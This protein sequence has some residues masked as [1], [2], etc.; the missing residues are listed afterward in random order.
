LFLLIIAQAVIFYRT[1]SSSF[2]V[3]YWW[4]G[5]AASILALAGVV[6]WN[7]LKQQ[8]TLSAR[9]NLFSL[10][11]SRISNWL[12]NVLSFN[13]LYH[14]LEVVYGGLFSVV[15]V[16]SETLE[17]EGGVLWALVLLAL[18]VSIIKTG[19]VAK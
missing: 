12:N 4:A 7:R 18:L 5:A 3:Q 8:T 9:Q 1:F 15:Q 2:R 16:L 6:A 10:I 17:G 19:V 14:I 13:W 11:T